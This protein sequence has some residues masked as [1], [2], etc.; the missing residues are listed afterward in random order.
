MAATL[1]FTI[2]RSQS[3]PDTKEK[4]K[5]IRIMKENNENY[6]NIQIE[7]ERRCC[8]VGLATNKVRIPS[9]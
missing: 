3:A 7:S 8:N 6:E 1:P 4:T 9:K 5:W 2:C